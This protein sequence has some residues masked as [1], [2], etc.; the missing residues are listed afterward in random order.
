[1]FGFIKQIFVLTMMFLSS[2]SSVNPLECVPMKNQEW[3]IRPEIVNLA[4][5]IL[6]FI[7]LV[8]K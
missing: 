2:L 1:M 6:Y 4:V 7:L 5:M 8:L 3:K